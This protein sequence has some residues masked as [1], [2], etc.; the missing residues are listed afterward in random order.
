LIEAL[1][2]VPS[3]Q[4]AVLVLRYFEGMDVSGAAKT[5]GC[6]EGN[7]KSQTS[8]GLAKLREMLGDKEV[9]AHG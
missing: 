2:L 4:R 9:D 7:V 3:R 8:R 1:K 6:S 5:L